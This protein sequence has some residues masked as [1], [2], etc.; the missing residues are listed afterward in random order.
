MCLCVCCV[1]CQCTILVGTKHTVEWTLVVPI[2][3]MGVI[4]AIHL[5]LT[6][7]MECRRDK[8]VT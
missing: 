1:L 8:L 2:I 7:P 3:A 6:D 4:L 5:I